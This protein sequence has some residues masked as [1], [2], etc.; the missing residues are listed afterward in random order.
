MTINFN[1]F[2]NEKYHV[3][4]D[5]RHLTNL[6]YNRINYFLSKLILNKEVEINSFLEKNY[7]RIKFKNDVIILKLGKNHGSINEPIYI[8]NCIEN[9]KIYLTI[10]LSKNELSNKYLINN[11]IR[12]T[13]NHEC[14]HIIEFYNTG[15]LSASCD[16]NKR[17]KIHKDKFKIYDKWLDIIHIFYLAEEHEIRSSISQLLEYIKNSDKNDIKDIKIYQ[18]LIHS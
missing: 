17:L 6:I 10:N 18:L 2:L 8:D 4:Q 5:V 15:D 9:L 14:Q 1:N 13:I 7:T 16:F 3:N 12:E 11:K